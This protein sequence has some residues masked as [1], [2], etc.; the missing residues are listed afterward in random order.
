MRRADGSQRIVHH[1]IDAIEVAREVGEPFAHLELEAVFPPDVYA[2]MLE[3]MPGERDYRPMSGRSR[4]VRSD[5]GV[6]TRTKMDLLPEQIRR[7][8]PEQ[9]AVWEPVG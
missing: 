2:A 5:D 6:P 7:L 4:E 8:A 9:R 1:V 3:H